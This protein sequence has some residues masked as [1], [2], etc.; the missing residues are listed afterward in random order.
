MSRVPLV[1]ALAAPAALLASAAPAQTP[2]WRVA[3]PRASQG[4]LPQRLLAAHNVERAAWRLPPLAWDPQLAEAAAAY[5]QM[6]APSGMLRHSNRAA[7]P[8]QGENLWLG[9]RGAFSPEQMV[10]IWTAERRY[11][12]PGIFPNV[13]SNGNWSSVGHYSQMVW[14]TTTRRGCAMAAGRGNDVLV[15]RYSPAGNID[16]RRVP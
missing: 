5:A 15:C 1:Q 4:N 13:S 9:T 7:R 12:R 6:L 3:P 2:Y 14:P 10:A 11:F 16:G 8:G